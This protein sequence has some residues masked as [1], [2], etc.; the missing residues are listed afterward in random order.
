MKNISLVKVTF[1]VG[2]MA[3]ASTLVS[4]N[5]LMPKDVPTLEV[6]LSAKLQF[7]Q[8]DIDKND[9]ISLVETEKHKTIYN[10]FTK[11]DSN[12]DATISRDEFTNFIK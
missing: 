6:P 11:I 9:S 7:E 4:A 5:E 8:L 2:I 1:T 10:S 12:D 3:V